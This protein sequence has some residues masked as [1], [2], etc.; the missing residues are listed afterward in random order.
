METE[1]KLSAFLFYCGTMYSSVGAYA[2]S[3][4]A[5]QVAS[6]FGH[7]PAT[8]ELGILMVH[9]KGGEVDIYEG[10]RL[11]HLAEQ[12]GDE[13]ASVALDSFLEF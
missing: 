11:L 12:A 2:M 7:V 8:R 6:D 13:T 9:G 5:F 10:S 1:T 4:Y 3:R